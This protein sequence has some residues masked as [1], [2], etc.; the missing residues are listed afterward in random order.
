MSL[1]LE[2]ISDTDLP[3][4][5]I[6]LVFLDLDGTVIDQSGIVS[7]TLQKQISKLQA[8]G[9]IFC[10]ATGRPYFAAKSVI[11]QLNISGVGM[12]D[13][14]AFIYDNSNQQT[15]F[16]A[17]LTKADLKNI[18][19]QARQLDLYA[20]LYTKDGFIVEKENIIAEIHSGYLAVR[21]KIEN[22]ENYMDTHIFKTVVAATNDQELVKLEKFKENLK[23]LNFNQGYGSDHPHITFLNT[24]SP[25][26]LRQDAFWKICQHYNVDS[27][28]V[29]A[30]GDAESD[31]IFFKLAGFGV[32]MGNAKAIVQAAARFVTKSLKDDGVCYALERFFIG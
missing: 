6:K 9:I 1:Q 31:T 32:A 4:N 30:F 2:K 23:G 25:L 26:A 15:I 16:S 8:Q 14:G 10:I 5:Q 27:K 18:V 17:P 21:P 3:K 12:Y 29:A 22:F 19:I 11:K 7:S 24:L 28:Q 20:E 13:S